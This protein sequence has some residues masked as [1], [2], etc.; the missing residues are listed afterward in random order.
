MTDDINTEADFQGEHTTDLGGEGV[1]DLVAQVGENETDADDEDPEL[2]TDGGQPVETFRFQD[3]DE[4]DEP[5]LT[6]TVTDSYEN[7]YGDVKAA[8]ETPAP[9]DTPDD[10][11][12]ANEV[13]KALPWGED[14]ADG[15]RDGAHYTFDE[16]R[17][18]WTLDQDYL[19]DLADLAEDAGYEWEGRARGEAEANEATAA[20]AQLRALAAAA[21][22]GDYIQATYVK[23]NGN[24]RNTYEG[25]V[26]RAQVGDDP[27][28]DEAWDTRRRRTRETG[29]IFTDEGGKTKRV[30]TDDDGTPALYSAGYHPFMGE[31]VYVDLEQ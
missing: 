13:V 7:R 6:F 5:D 12:P 14:D 22:A 27:S 25:V 10:V 30:R 16:D 31:L 1:A 21:E 24:G 11:T 26:E 3:E 28:E 9:W 2:V 17:E 29:V 20:Q 19:R 4:A 8:V 18:A 23:K 15:D